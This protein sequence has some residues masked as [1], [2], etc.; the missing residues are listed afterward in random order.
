MHRRLLLTAAAFAAL[1][2]SGSA[3][4]A[5]E[6]TLGYVFGSYAIPYGYR[7]SRDNGRTTSGPDRTKTGLGLGALGF[8]AGIGYNGWNLQLDVRDASKATAGALTGGYR[9]NFPLGHFELWGRLAIGPSL[10]IDY[11]QASHT[12]IAGGVQTVA[13]VG[14]DYL[15]WD[16]LAVG[17][18]GVAEPN[19]SWKS[20]FAADFGL[21][22]D[23]RLLI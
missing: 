1:V 22:I 13:E 8:G 3:S 12:K 5:A 23:V 16:H 17:L 18:K 9:L 11:H 2:L 21:N 19:Y 20:N 15:F 4:R 7:V 6:P 14:L 10:A